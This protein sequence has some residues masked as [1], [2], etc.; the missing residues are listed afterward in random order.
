MEQLVYYKSPPVRSSLASRGGF[1]RWFFG[2]FASLVGIRCISCLVSLLGLKTA[3]GA[4]LVTTISSAQIVFALFQSMR[5]FY[6]CHA[7]RPFF[8]LFV[9]STWTWH[10]CCRWL[11][12]KYW[13]TTSR[14]SGCEVKWLCEVWAGWFVRIPITGRNIQAQHTVESF[15]LWRC[16][17]CTLGLA[18]KSRVPWQ[19]SVSETL[20]PDR[21]GPFQL[22]FRCKLCWS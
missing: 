5:F 8:N 10:R 19:T 20:G 13:D 1:R 21:E 11:L 18:H 7:A 15:C 3:T 2:S 6:Y 14:Q 17:N 22:F 16:P 12:L 9:I 4:C